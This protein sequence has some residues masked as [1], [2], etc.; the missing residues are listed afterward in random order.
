MAFIWYLK[1]IGANPNLPGS[2]SPVGATPPSCIGN[3]KICAI[4]ADESGIPGQPDIDDD[5]QQQ[6]VLALSIPAD[7]TRVLLRTIY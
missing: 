4:F 6:M 1:A 3:G 2:Y 7:Q 5:L